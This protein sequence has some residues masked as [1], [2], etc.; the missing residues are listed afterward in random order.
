MGCY[1]NSVLSASTQSHS[2]ARLLLS[3]NL[4]MGGPPEAAVRTRFV[5]DL[6][7]GFGP[8]IMG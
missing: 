8:F 5:A 4:T 3:W 2:S 6:G 1:I 7:A